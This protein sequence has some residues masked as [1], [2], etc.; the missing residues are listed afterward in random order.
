MRTIQKF[1]LAAILLTLTLCS[2]CVVNL[3]MG[4][5]LNDRENLVLETLE[6]P[7]GFF[8]HDKV[9][10]ITLD[11]IISAGPTTSKGA[12]GA[13]RVSMLVKL[14]DMLDRAE[15]NT[16]I[17]SVLIKINS[18]GGG[19]TASDLIY[20]EIITFKERSHKPVV[21]ICMDVAASGGYYVAMAADHVVMHPT[22][23]TGSIGVIAVFPKAKSLGDKIGLDMRVIKSGKMKDIGSLW[24][25]F[26]PEEQQVLQQMIDTMYE[27][28]L[29][30]VQA[31]RP[32]LDREVIRELADGRI[33]TAQQALEHG[34][35]DEIGYVDDAFTAAQRKAGL[36][37]AALVA[38]KSRYG[39]RGH[40]YAKAP[41]GLPRQTTNNTTQI[42]LLNLDL[43][44]GQSA[45]Q[46]G[47]PFH[48][49]WMP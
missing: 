8:V 32:R 11:G 23:V 47:G 28:F 35:A 20:H 36:S 41:S 6:K 1:Q 37:D 4:G 38:Y 39:Y 2:G 15:K 43:G 10:L 44:I 34:L 14:K 13:Q 12:F 29:D 31:G 17:K 7:K 19:V 18:P 40:Y 48:Y 42:N 33:Y 5:Y 24:R 16:L 9:L 21:V 45:W 26:E 22:T 3:N 49:L 25:D 30:V 46:N 27:H